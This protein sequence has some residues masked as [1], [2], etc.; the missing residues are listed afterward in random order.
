M[1]SR[2]FV[3]PDGHQWGVLHIDASHAD[4]SQLPTQ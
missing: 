3:D 1:Y 2:A 4:M